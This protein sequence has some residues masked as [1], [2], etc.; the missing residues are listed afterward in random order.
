MDTKDIITLI[1]IFLTLLV[2][3]FSLYISFKNS[4]KTL[5]INSV[6]ASRIR[7]IDNLRENISSYCGHTYHLSL[8]EITESEK[9]KIIKSIDIL[10]F[11]IKL[12]LNRG[13]KLDEMILQK[14]DDIP[15]LTDSSKIELL[16]QAINELIIMTQDLL[17]DE[18]ERVKR[19]SIN[20]P[21][22]KSK[23]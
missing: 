11:K 2:S 5:F 10:R 3:T 4:R 21:I 1:G 8:T 12:Q 19:E 7:W 23:K 16:A 15:N 9:Q 13:D 18:W 22:Y 20:G 17:K 14:I 6:T